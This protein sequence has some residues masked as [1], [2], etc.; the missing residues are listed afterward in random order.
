SVH[1]AAGVGC[2]S[3]H[4]RIDK[5]ETVQQDQP[6]SMS[7]CL[8]CHRNPTPHLRPKDQVTNMRYNPA[9]A[10]YNPAGDPART[11]ELA[12]PTHCSGCHR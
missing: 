3:C 10:G 5:M 9:T 2:A 12:P 4:G 1:V 8:D 11:R 7:W 6:L